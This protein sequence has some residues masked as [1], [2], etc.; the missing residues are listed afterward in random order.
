[1]PFY[2][3]SGN[4]NCKF[5]TNFCR[6]GIMLKQRRRN[7]VLITH[8]VKRLTWSKCLSNISYIDS[9]NRFKLPL[10]IRFF[11]IIY[12]VYH[13]H[14]IT[15]W[16]KLAM[17]VIFQ[18]FPYRDLYFYFSFQNHHSLQIM[19]SYMTSFHSS[20]STVNGFNQQ[21]TFVYVIW[22]SRWL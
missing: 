2:L 9:D 1:M 21:V 6:M 22:L 12:F 5:M 18:M 3:F 11:H 20:R 15:H 7:S 10:V 4:K 17:I 16:A 13:M 8:G 19:P 14:H